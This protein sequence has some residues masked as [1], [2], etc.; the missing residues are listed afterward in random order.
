MEAAWDTM[1]LFL[2][3][4]DRRKPEE[5][6]IP[7]TPYISLYPVGSK[8]CVSLHRNEVLLCGRSCA[9]VP[10]VRTVSMLSLERLRVACWIGQFSR[11]KIDLVVGLDKQQPHLA[12][13]KIATAVIKTQEKVATPSC[14]QVKPI[15]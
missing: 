8:W 12:F 5:R 13:G 4:D 10:S 3:E 15:L 1:L 2:C 9:A 6:N 11:P 7:Y 14:W